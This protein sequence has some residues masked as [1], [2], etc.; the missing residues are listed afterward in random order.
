MEAAR[1]GEP[2][3]RMKPV[4]RKPSESDK[5]LWAPTPVG[6]RPSLTRSV[7]LSFDFKEEADLPGTFSAIGEL[8][9]SASDGSMP[10]HRQKRDY[11]R[12]ATMSTPNLTRLT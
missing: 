9:E 2:G 6:L 10:V 5:A 3:V 8:L 11:N 1:L 12:C 7:P 4:L